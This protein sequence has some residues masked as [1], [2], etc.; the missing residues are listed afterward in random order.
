MT[1]LASSI[2]GRGLIL[3]NAG[4]DPKI[5]ISRKRMQIE[6]TQASFRFGSRSAA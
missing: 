1:A 2:G 5:P 6:F 4:L 3:I